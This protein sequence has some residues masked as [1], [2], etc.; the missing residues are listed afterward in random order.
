[1]ISKFKSRVAPKRKGFWSH[2][3]SATAIL[4]AEHSV[5]QAEK[6]IEQLSQTNALLSSAKDHAN[7]Q[8]AAQENLANEAHATLAEYHFLRTCI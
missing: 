7:Q 6:E 5:K 3:K 1:M 4:E 2:F 8:H